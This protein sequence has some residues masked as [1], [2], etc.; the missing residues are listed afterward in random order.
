MAE[1]GVNP[2]PDFAGAILPAQASTPAS[3]KAWNGSDPAPRF[4]V[5]RNNVITSLVGALADGFPVTRALTS[6]LT[7]LLR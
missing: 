4:A 7:T 2:L 1:R 6:E 5:H 3:L